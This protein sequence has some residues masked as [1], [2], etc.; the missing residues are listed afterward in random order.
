MRVEH[1]P[2]LECFG[3]IIEHGGRRVGYS[4]DTRLCD[5]LRAIAAG[6]D[7]LVLECNQAHGGPPSHMT[8]DGVRALR[9]EFPGV[10]FILTHVGAGVSVAG[11]TGTRIAA[12]FETIHV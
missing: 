11:I 3:Y 8:L 12:D 10:P 9:A 6:C 4:G 1:V 5:G 2:E 7:T